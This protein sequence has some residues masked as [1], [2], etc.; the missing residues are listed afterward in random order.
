[1]H[2]ALT[3]AHTAHTTHTAVQTAAPPS[4]ASCTTPAA[5]RVDAAS[6]EPA[7]PVK[8]RS[9]PAEEFGAALEAAGYAKYGT[10]T[11]I[12]GLTGE[13]MPCDIYIGLV[14]YQRLRHMVSDK[15]Q[16]ILADMH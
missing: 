7:L 4:D 8:Q 5:A 3:A 1:M 14:Y 6:G 9:N 2:A 13:E 15:F 16:V 11:M 12:S 10:E